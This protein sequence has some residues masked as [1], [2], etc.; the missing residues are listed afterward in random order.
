MNGT[1]QHKAH[2]PNRF[3]DTFAKL[4]QATISFNMFYVSVEAFAATEFSKIFWGREQ[5]QGVKILHP[6]A[7][8]FVMF[9]RPST[10]NSSATTG[11][12]LIKFDIGGLFENPSRKPTFH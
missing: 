6:D 1:S 8:E 10:W 7:P 5:C 11:R 4:R 12:I 2:L 9:V 3:L